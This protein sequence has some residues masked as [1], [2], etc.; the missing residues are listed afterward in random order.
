MIIILLIFTC[1]WQCDDK[2]PMYKGVS[3]YS[4][5]IAAAKENNDFQ[6]FLESVCKSSTPNLSPIAE[7]QVAQAERD[8]V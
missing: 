6:S 2:C 4:N 3:L 1:I 8:S 5:V 7:C